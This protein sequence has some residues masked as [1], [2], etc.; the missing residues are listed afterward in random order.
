MQLI[1]VSSPR[2]L[3]KESE[4]IRCLFDAGLQTFHLR[5]PDA[6]SD[7]IRHL[8]DMIPGKYHSCIVLHDAFSLTAAYP[9]KGIHLNKR[10]QIVPEGFSGSIS[11]S[12]HSIEEVQTCVNQYDYVFLSPIFDSISKEGYRSRFSET[13][14]FDAAQTGII[15]RKVIAL[16][17]IDE[18]SLSRIVPFG[19]GGVAVLGMLWNQFETTTDLDSLLARYRII[20]RMLETL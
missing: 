19:F 17:G 10:N 5:K 8:L 18:Y 13:D 14:L 9:V 15:N 6:G 16:G 3:E 11:R 12:C 1:A 20:V 4:A 7:S 2:F